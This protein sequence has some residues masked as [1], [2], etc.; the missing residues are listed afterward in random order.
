MLITGDVIHPQ[1]GGRSARSS[2]WAV[3]A[4]MNITYVPAGRHHLVATWGGREVSGDV[5]VNNGYRT[6]VTINFAPNA[7]PLTF[8]YEP[9]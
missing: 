4:V 3:A 5:L 7:T 8:S 1:D 9:E 2:I 6:V